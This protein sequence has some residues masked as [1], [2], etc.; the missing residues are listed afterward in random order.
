MITNLP[1]AQIAYVVPDIRKACVQHA[2]L[3]GTGPFYIANNIPFSWSKYRGKDASF[4]HSSAFS[5][6][7]DVMI[8]FM[9]REDDRPS[10]LTDVLDRTGGKASMHHKA[11]LVADPPAVATQF[12]QSGF[13]IAFHGALTAGIEVFM[14]DTLD[15]YG[16]MIELYAPSETVRGFFAMIR[17]NSAKF[18]GRELLREFSFE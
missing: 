12:E 10:V 3:F 18:D 11:I 7:G 9:Q 16:H 2:E 8:E 4:N 1:V 5:Q 13:R 15:L 6:W 17:E 14:I